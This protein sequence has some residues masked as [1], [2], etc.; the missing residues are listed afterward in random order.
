MNICQLYFVLIFG[1]Y[2]IVVDNH[3]HFVYPED[4]CKMLGKFREI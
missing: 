2:L 3:F 4:Q 1:A